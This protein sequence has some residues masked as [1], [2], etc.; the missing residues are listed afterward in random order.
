MLV[1]Q[2]STAEQRHRDEVF[3]LLGRRGDNQPQKQDKTSML[4]IALMS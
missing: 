1:L 4:F 2:A 3:E